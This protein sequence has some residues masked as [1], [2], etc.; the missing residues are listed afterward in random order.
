MAYTTKATNILTNNEAAQ[1]GGNNR[2]WTIEVADWSDEASTGLTIELE[3]VAAGQVAKDFAVYVPTSLDGGASTEVTL[4]VGYDYVSGTD[5]DNAFI[6][7][8]H[9]HA[10]TSTVQYSYG[11][12]TSNS[13]ISFDS[14][15][16]VDAVLTSAG[17]NLSVVTSGQ[18]EIYGTI[19]DTTDGA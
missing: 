11:A 12:G 18:I 9:V 8:T 13:G 16:T 4:E 2:R 10:D 14:A 17:G 15:A 1:H 6:A 7:S 3:T 5:D 19:Y